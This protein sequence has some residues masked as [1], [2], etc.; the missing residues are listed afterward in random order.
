MRWF[1]V[2]SIKNFRHKQ[3]LYIFTKKY[4]NENIIRLI[5]FV[6]PAISILFG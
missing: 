3:M 5:R 1:F 6:F 4:S 2:F